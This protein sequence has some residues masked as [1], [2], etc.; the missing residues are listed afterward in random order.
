[1]HKGKRG[2]MSHHKERANPTSL[3]LSF[4]PGPLCWT[5]P[6]PTGEAVFFTQSTDSTVNLF[7]KHCQKHTQKKCFTAIW[8]SLIQVKLTHKIKH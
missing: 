3:R 4:H 1:M 6:T 5:M 2:W 7:W 8:A